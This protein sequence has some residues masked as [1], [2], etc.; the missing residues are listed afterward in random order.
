M[1]LMLFGAAFQLS[2]S[3]SLRKSGKIGS[4]FEATEVLPLQGSSVWYID[5][6]HPYLHG[7]AYLG[8]PKPS[9]TLFWAPKN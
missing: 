6:Y 1:V 2:S 7:F 4:E 5:D 3:F 9:K 8:H